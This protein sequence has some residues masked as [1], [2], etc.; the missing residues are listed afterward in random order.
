[1]PI[2]PKGHQSDDPVDCDICG[3]SMTGGTPAPPA[4]AEPEWDC[5]N[6]HPGQIGRFCEVD[7]YDSHLPADAPDQVRAAAPRRWVATVGADRE[8]YDLTCADDDSLVF[9]TRLVP[10]RFTLRGE[11]LL[12]GRKDP[13]LGIHPEIDLT[14]PPEDRAVGREHAALVAQDDGTWAVVDRGSANGTHVNDRVRPIPPKK[15]VPLRS[16]DQVFVGAWTV[17]TINAE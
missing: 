15:P 2:C 3:G 9:P 4:V 5:P 12:I 13:E 6:G 10:R 1:M 7:G 11:A 8:F 14:G 17:I 16:G